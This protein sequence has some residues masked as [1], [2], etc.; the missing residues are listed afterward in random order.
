MTVRSSKLFGM[1]NIIESS[2]RNMAG[3]KD[4]AKY[5]GVS[6]A[7]VSR[8]LTNTAF[9]SPKTKEKVEKA[10]K[11]LN[12][13]PNKVAQSLRLQRANIVGLIIPDIE[14]TFFTRLSRAIEDAAYL[15]KKTIFLCNT[16]QRPDREE[17]YL[18]V[19]EDE[20]VAGII[21]APTRSSTDLLKVYQDSQLPIVFVDRNI[22][23]FG[24]DSVILNNFQAGFDL[25]SHLIQQGNRHIAAIFNNDSNTGFERYKGYCAALEENKIAIEPQITIFAN[26]H[27]QDGFEAT[28]KLLQS[29]LK[30]DSLITTNG[31]LAA[32]ALRYLAENKIQIPKDIAFA[33]IDETQWS[34]IVSPQV[35]V[36]QQPVKEM[37]EKTIELILDKI[38]NPPKKKEHFVYEAKLIVRESSL[39][40]H[41][42]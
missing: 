18:K 25:T 13:R 7:T 33:T 27:E 21:I 36:M 19:M 5:A 23:N 20:N 6:T 8:V 32:G 12:Y 17:H 37:G 28:K 29:N 10:V 39:S 41:F 3:I 9:V 24:C 16:D 15:H 22:E 38:K 11:S 31:L 30:I 2:K 35:T 34:R 14:N 26:A 42:R 4:V 1:Y 40:K